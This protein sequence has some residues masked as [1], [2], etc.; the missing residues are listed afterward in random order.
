VSRLDDMG[1]R[2]LNL[3]LLQSEGKEKAES[4]HVHN[5]HID[6]LLHDI[7]SKHLYNI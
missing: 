2:T 4:L 3:R 5:D 6:K 7:V 1:R